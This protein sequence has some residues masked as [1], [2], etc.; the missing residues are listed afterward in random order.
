MAERKKPN[1][2]RVPP[3]RYKGVGIGLGSSD[4]ANLDA[5][6][7]NARALAA[8]RP[9]SLQN[10]RRL[11]QLSPVRTA[12]LETHAQILND[13]Q[14]VANVIALRKQAKQGV[15]KS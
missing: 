12:L 14:E 9:E 1:V 8:K 11:N 3:R 13:A 15:V 6:E 2:E 10:L 4:A 7:R 5:V